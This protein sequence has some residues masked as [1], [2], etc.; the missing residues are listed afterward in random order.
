M[1]CVQFQVQG[2]VKIVRARVKIKDLNARLFY[3]FPLKIKLRYTCC[4]LHIQINKNS[5][6]QNFVCLN[7]A[8]TAS[9][10]WTAL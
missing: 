4:D 6:H 9:F 8:K 1:F 5:P 10:V 3:K 7:T 2:L